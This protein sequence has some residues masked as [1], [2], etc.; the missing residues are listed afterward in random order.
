MI[1]G[2]LSPSTQLVDKITKRNLYA[3]CGVKEYWLIDPDAKLAEVYYLDGEG[4]CLT[5]AY[6]P[7]ILRQGCLCLAASSTLANCLRN[8]ITLLPIPA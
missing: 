7:A 4:Y 6:A 8:S 2:V 5:G 1:A 3:R